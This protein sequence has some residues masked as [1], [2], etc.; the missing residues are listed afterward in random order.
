MFSP[1]TAASDCTDL[2]GLAGLAMLRRTLADRVRAAEGHCTE[3]GACA[4][5]PDERSGACDRLGVEQLGEAVYLAF[6]RFTAEDKCMDALRSDASA[7]GHVLAHKEDHSEIS[8]RL[9]ALAHN[10]DGK[11]PCR[12][13][14]ELA[15]QLRIWLHEHVAAYDLPLQE[16]L[17]K[18]AAQGRDQR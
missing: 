3:D 14:R 16:L 12:G 17:A 1:H 10:W 13:F 7:R 5:C 4:S 18:Q 8:S 11:R 2:T 9:S 6:Q 15:E